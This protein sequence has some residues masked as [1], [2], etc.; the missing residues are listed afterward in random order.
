M[1]QGIKAIFDVAIRKG[2]T[3]LKFKK[4]ESTPIRLS[5]EGESRIIV[6]RRGNL[7]HGDFSPPLAG[8]LFFGGERVTIEGTP[9]FIERCIQPA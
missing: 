1:H 7:V 9:D 5:E 8:H 4:Q 3:Q 2:G 6:H